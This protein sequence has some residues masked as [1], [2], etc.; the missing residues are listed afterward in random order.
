MKIISTDSAPKAIGPYSQAIVAGNLAFC[1]GCI[2][3]N[4]VSMKVEAQTIEEQTTQ[5]IKNMQ[6]VL[7]GAGSSLSKVVKTTVFLKDMNDFQQM[8][9]VYERMFEGH[10]PA[11]STVQVAK[12][13]L[14]VMVEIECVA[15]V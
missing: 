14:D 3:L 10:K 7:Q 8:N 9:G 15:V 13:P 2:P 1:S 5:V 4:P 6:A 12:L 11:R